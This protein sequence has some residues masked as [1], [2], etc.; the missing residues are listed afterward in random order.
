MFIPS[1]FHAISSTIPTSQPIKTLQDLLEQLRLYSRAQFTGQLTLNCSNDVWRLYLY[2][3][4]WVG[5][6]SATHAIRRWCRQLIQ[7]CPSLVNSAASNPPSPYWNYTTLMGFV[8]QQKI[9]QQQVTAIVKGNLVEILF[10]VIQ[11]QHQNRD[12]AVL[13]LTQQSQEPQESVSIPPSIPMEAV[14]SQALP[15]WQA[16]QR[17]G[18]ANHSPNLVPVIRDTQQLQQQT[19]PLIFKNLVKLLD[20]DRTLRDLAIQL[21]QH[22]VPLTGSILPYVQQGVIE[23]KSAPD[24]KH[25]RQISPPPVYPSPAAVTAP[26][27]AYIEDNRFDSLAMSQVL[28]QAGYRFINIRDP[29][30]TLPILLERKPQLIFLDL[31]MPV[32]NGYEV[33]G[34]IR[35]ISAFKETPIVI[36]TSS[37]GLVDR[38][39][40][41]L[42]GSSDFLSKPITPEKVQMILNRYL[43]I[44]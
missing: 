34:Q 9:D 12:R 25:T 35:R 16:W 19:S 43:P 7:H 39:R 32:T 17:A 41:K 21:K 31:L 15:M 3:G 33:C 22:L 29:L 10:D 5:G 23:L 24:L 40:A 36:V 42:V 13:Q 14:L 1:P 30:L 6:T 38:V 27:V 20:C 44:S 37:D 18:L 2:Q 11:G 28:A 26:L 4:R 8:E